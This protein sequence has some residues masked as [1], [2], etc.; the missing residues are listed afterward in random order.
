MKTTLSIILLYLLF[1]VYVLSNNI[2]CTGHDACKNKVWSGEYNIYCGASNSERTCKNTVLNCGEGDDCLI[3]TLGSGHDAY[4]SSTVNAKTSASFKLYCQASGQRDCRSITV[5]CP[6]ESG[7]TCECISCPSTVTFKCVQ[8]VSCSSV[9]NA[10]IDYVQ[11]DT[12]SIPD[13]IW[14]KD[15]AHT[16]KRPDCPFSKTTNVQNYVWATLTN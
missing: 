7:S 11:S 6:Q 5:W 3:K 4:Q 13:S 14:Y 2:Y 12:Y 16:G 15:S 10:H 9:S 1:P 8:G